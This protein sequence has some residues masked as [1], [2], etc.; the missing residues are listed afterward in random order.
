MTFQGQW[1]Q[2]KK[3][4]NVNENNIVKNA[5]WQEAEQLAIYKSSRGVEQVITENNT[6]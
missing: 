3:Q 1:K 5:N 2:A 6:R 4:V